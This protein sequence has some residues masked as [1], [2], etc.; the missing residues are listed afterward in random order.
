MP[1]HKNDYLI[2]AGDVTDN[3][4]IFK[5]VLQILAGKY[6]K[7][8]FVPGNHD[9]WI[10]SSECA[11]NNSIEKLEQVLK[12]CKMYNVSTEPEKVKL[13]D[14]EYVH[15]IPIYSW[16]S[17]PEDDDRNSLYVRAKTRRDDEDKHLWMDNYLTKWPDFKDARSVSE[18]FFKMNERTLNATYDDAPV[19]T[20]SHFLPRRDLIRAT[21]N[22]EDIWR[23]RRSPETSEYKPTPFNFTRYAGCR[24]IEDAIRKLKSVVHVYGHQHRNRDRL[25]NG[26]RYVSHC[27]GNPKERENGLVWGIEDNAKCIWPF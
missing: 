22:E 9:I 5:E 7:V 1:E 11:F 24:R 13:D 19:I 4:K 18:F 23:M 16:Y 17:T 2:L 21:R 8:F 3:Q 27:L 25:I 6:R 12:T 15:I 14:N 20:F 10:R 26:I